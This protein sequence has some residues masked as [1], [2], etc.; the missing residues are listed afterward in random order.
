LAIAVVGVAAG[1]ALSLVSARAMTKLV[2]GVLPTDPST[3]GAAAA[4]ILVSTLVASWLPAFRSGR[5][6]PVTVLRED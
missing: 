4:I 1:C 5:V 6:D 3:L 2:F